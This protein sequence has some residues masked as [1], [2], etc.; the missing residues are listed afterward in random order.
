MR[1]REL[2]FTPRGAPRY[3]LPAL[4]VVVLT[5]AFGWGGLRLVQRAL[6]DEERAETLM[7][8]G[9]HAAAEALYVRLLHERPSVPL[10]IAF[11]ENHQ[12]AELVKRIRRKARGVVDDVT[13]ISRLE[14][15]MSPDSLDAIV[16]GLPAEISRI[17]RFYRAVDDDAV[18]RALHEEIE[19]GAKQEP[20]LPWCNHMLAREAFRHQEARTAADH[21]AREGISFPERHEDVDL[22]IA[23]WM[24]LDDWDEVERRMAEPRFSAAAEPMTRYR[25][26]VHRR[27]VMGAVKALAASWK[28]R[29][30]LPGFVM[31]AVAALAWGCFCARLGK[32]GDR[33]RLRIPLYLVAFVL[34]VLSIP[35][36]IALIAVEEAHLKLVETGDPARDLL[37]FVFG[38]GLREEAAKLLLFVP[39][40]PALRKWGDKL[41]VLVCGGMVGLG[42][43]AE[44]N[45]GYLASGDL[46]TGLGRFLTANF[47]HI[48]LTSILASALDDFIREPEKHAAAFSR[49][50]LMVVGMHGVYDFLLTHEQFGGSYLA[51]AVFFF[52]VRMFLGA[53][54]H[55]RRKAD[56]GL[57]LTQVFVLSLAVVTGTSAVYAVAT[58]GPLEGAKV[59]TEGLLGVAILIYAFVRSLRA[60]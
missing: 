27:D 35:P 9:K 47:L 37:F 48:A 19:A 29:F 17:G 22:A 32:L 38:V 20:P 4:V 6:P 1:L 54:E 18:P 21:Y 10:V 26:A 51:M 43:A 15:V 31:A 45:L 33:P 53:V 58:V 55:A 24:S 40:L 49:T 36:T 7:H 46:H 30:T 14:E 13:D 25:F 11:L 60:M 57:D 59:M 56:K 41:D 5:F 12:R 28:P 23:I 50:S 39:L 16:D 52:L 3:V 42:F 2:F 8:S 34:G 44:E